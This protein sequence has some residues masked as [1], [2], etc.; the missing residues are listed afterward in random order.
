M[1]KNSLYPYLIKNR[2]LN[3]KIGLLLLAWTILTPG[4]K[5]QR[6][7][8]NTDSKF[9]YAL[10]T[11][12]DAALI[13]GGTALLYTSGFTQEILEPLNKQEIELLNPNS[14]P[15]YDRFATR[16]WNQVLND[17]RESFEPAAI[18]GSM[19]LVAAL[20]IDQKLKNHS[21]TPLKTLTLM[22]IEGAYLTEGIV[23]LTKSIVKRPRPYTYNSS[24]STDIKIR[25]ANN[26]SF[27]SGNAGILF[28]NATFA[29]Q[30]VTDIFPDSRWIPYIWAGTHGLALLSGFWSV[31]SGMHFPSDILA[32]AAWG[33]GMALLITRLHKSESNKIKIFP[34]ASAYSKGATLIVNL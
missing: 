24:L 33:S 3:Q 17:R 21:W 14:L 19:G 13:I 30:I 9:P 18:L 16:N 31:K 26:E 23:L 6:T 20:G 28:Y 12:K 32:G 4:L 7:D 27:I 22:Y 2:T 25:P 5:A 29:S 1:K 8:H 15:F 34:W 10:S 11:Y